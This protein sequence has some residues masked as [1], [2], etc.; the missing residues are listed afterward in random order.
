MLKI[1]ICGITNAV[2]AL[3]ACEY[4][5]DALGFIFAKSPRKINPKAAKQIIKRVPRF[6]ARVG[7]FVNADKAD[8][9]RIIKECG[10]DTLQFHGEETDKYCAFFQKYCK[11]IKAFRIK[12]K[13]SIN[14]IKNYNHAHAYLLDSYSKDVYG[15]TG[16]T[17]SYNLLRNTRFK[18]PVIIS[19]G[20][21]EKN[22]RKIANTLHP[23]A[24][25]VSSSIER[26]PGKKNLKK[27]RDL[28][29]QVKLLQI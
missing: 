8:V 2:D 12:D 9:L 14:A 15:G 10:L 29:K 27:M 23:F 13:Y 5:A 20:I 4:G 11:I 25:D 28:I 1:K 24:F 22:W 17:F 21:N 19:G 7:V 16:Y 26:S 6:I 18:R 3:K